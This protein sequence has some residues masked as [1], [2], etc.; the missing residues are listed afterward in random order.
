MNGPVWV[1]NATPPPVIVNVNLDKEPNYEL[2]ENEDDIDDVYRT[3]SDHQKEFKE[4]KDK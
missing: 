2:K 4:D 1:F 3:N